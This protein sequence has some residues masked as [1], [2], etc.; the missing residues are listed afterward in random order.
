MSAVAF[1]IFVIGFPCCFFAMFGYL[2][3]KFFNNEES[4]VGAYKREKE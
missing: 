1:D 2:G 3:Y 4:D